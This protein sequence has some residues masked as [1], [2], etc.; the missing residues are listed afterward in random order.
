LFVFDFALS[1][2]LQTHVYK[3]KINLKN[4]ELRSN[5]KLFYPRQLALS[6]ELEAV[7]ASLTKVP[8]SENRNTHNLRRQLN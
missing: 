7:M 4:N 1:S 5:D 2:W 8:R 6:S 3:I